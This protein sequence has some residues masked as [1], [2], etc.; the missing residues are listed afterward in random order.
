MFEALASNGGL[1]LEA[2]KEKYTDSA[3]DRFVAKIEAGLDSHCAYLKDTA[4]PE[5]REI[6]NSYRRDLFVLNTREIVITR[7][8][9]TSSEERKE[10]IEGKLDKLQELKSELEKGIALCE[11]RA[12][13]LQDTIERYNECK[14]E[15]EQKDSD[16][17]SR[18]MAASNTEKEAL[19]ER[20]QWSI[21]PRM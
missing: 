18:Y 14:A 5:I 17:K 15:L 10:K 3:M 2:L 1:S 16:A 6:E 4:L 11:A 20:M 19:E 13:R 21:S 8:L 12:E 9:D 7:E